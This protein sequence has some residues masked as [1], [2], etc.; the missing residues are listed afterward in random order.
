[1]V[2][3]PSQL[4]LI[5]QPDA[6]IAG[7]RRRAHDCAVAVADRRER[8]R[9]LD[10][11]PVLA[12]TDR[13]EVVDLVACPDP[14]QQLR[15]LVVEPG[16]DENRHRLADDLIG[17][18]AEEALGAAI[19]G[20]D[21]S[22]EVLADDGIV[23]GLDHGPVHRSIVVGP[24]ALGD[25]PD[26]ARDAQPLVGAEGAEGDFDRELAAVLSTSVQLVSDTHRARLRVHR[27]GGAV[28]GMARA[29]AVRDERLDLPAHELVA[30]VAEEL[31]GLRVHEQDRTGLVHDDH[32]VRSPLETAVDI[33]P[34]VQVLG[35]VP[36][37]VRRH[38]HSMLSTPRLP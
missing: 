28:V 15:C 37:P 14:V 4:F 19:P 10:L 22:V 13:L 35:S 20:Q 38:T 6:D 30:A 17:G 27:E 18:V 23:G 5:A 12:L 34:S 33:V 26:G 21:R 29:G 24:A 9:H 11:G 32:A 25:V 7:D 8:Q 2:R 3:Q 31:L 36:A 16:G 1:M